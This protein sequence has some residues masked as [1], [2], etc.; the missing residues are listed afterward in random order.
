[1]PGPESM[2][3]QSLEKALDISA[4]EIVK[5]SATVAAQRA[6][7][8]ACEEEC[9]QLRKSITILNA[10][11]DVHKAKTNGLAQEFGPHNPGDISL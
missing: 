5:L 1:M 4:K 11:L 2:K 8:K 10:Q 3:I 7:R 6:M 9:A